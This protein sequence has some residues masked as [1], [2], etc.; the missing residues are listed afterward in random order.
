MRRGT[1]GFDTTMILLFNVQVVDVATRTK[2]Q[3]GFNNRVEAQQGTYAFSW[4]CLSLLL[5]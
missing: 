4:R 1:L 5:Y 2:N 3:K